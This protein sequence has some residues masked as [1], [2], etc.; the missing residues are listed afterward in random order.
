M[1]VQA[2]CLHANQE[3]HSLIDTLALHGRDIATLV[4]R[5]ILSWNVE[6]RRTPAGRG[7]AHYHK[8][9][10]G[11]STIVSQ[12]SFLHIPLKVLVAL[13]STVGA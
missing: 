5:V 13:M 4:S 6:I 1:F 7:T 2:A 12:T 11:M 9:E 8:L 3:D 10:S